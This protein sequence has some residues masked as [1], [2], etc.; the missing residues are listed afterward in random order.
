MNLRETQAA[1]TREKLFISARS[2]FAKKGYKGTSVREIN[3]SVG[4]ADG[5][6]YHYFPGGKADIFRNVL[7]EESSRIIASFPADGRLAVYKEMPLSVMLSEIYRDFSDIIQENLDIIRILFRETEALNT[8]T[9]GDNSSMF[10]EKPRWFIDLLKEKHARGEVR[11][12]DFESASDIYTGILF[13]RVLELV[14]DNRD[15]MICVSRNKLFDHLADL[16]KA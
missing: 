14:F 15:E 11:L 7:E 10:Y 6:L 9:D 13:S 12:M 5:L 8:V 1:E 3:R 2:L 16:W 4:L